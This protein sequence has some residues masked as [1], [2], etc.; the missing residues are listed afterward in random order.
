MKVRLTD[1]LLRV[2]MFF[3]LFSFVLG[4]LPS[5][6][7]NTPNDPPEMP[8]TVVE[9]EIVIVDKN[10][11]EISRTPSNLQGF[12]SLRGAKEGYVETEKGKITG[13]GVFPIGYTATIQVIEVNPA[14]YKFKGMYFTSVPTTW[15][16]THAPFSSYGPNTLCS[17]AT[18]KIPISSGVTSIKVIAIFE[19]SGTS[20]VIE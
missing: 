20:F 15:V 3:S 17:F 8:Q 1:S 9:G 10:G 7:K 12:S 18:I 4:V 19:E 14:K 6:D 11:K 16:S 2:G 5:C 13:L